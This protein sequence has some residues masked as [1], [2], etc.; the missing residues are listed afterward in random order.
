MP[1]LLLR[2]LAF[3]GYLPF[4]IDNESGGGEIAVVENGITGTEADT[5]DFSSDMAALAQEIA[6]RDE[7]ET[8]AVSTGK[9]TTPVAE[10]PAPGASETAEK[11]P[12]AG[13]PPAPGPRDTTKAP[14]TWKKE[15]A[16]L[17]SKLDPV[18]QKEIHRREEENY[19]GLAAYKADADIGKAAKTTFAPYEQPFTMYKV[20]RWALVHELLGINHGLALGTK[21]QKLSIFNFILKRYGM[22]PQDLGVPAPADAPF[23]DPQVT[24]LQAE[25]DRLKGNFNGINQNLAAE[26]TARAAAIVTAFQAAP[27]HEHFERVASGINVLMRANPQ[28]TLEQA[29]ET[30]CWADPE[31]RQELLDAQAAAAEAAEKETAKTAAAA[32]RAAKA[33][34]RTQARPVTATGKE[35]LGS[36]DDTLKQ[37]LAA[38][39]ARGD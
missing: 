27:G 15:P 25:V 28:L 39:K 36:V 10:T 21:E 2:L 7:N 12:V 19:V 13:T 9:K 38:I 14:K 35:D 33:A 1:K 11:P 16:A 3:A 22:T 18:I 30:A 31:V 20:D 29:Y 4:H 32:A 6:S 23:V 24:A 17:F 34:P 26:R 8:P 37:T 5:F